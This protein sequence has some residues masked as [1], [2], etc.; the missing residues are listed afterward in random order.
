MKIEKQVD[1]SKYEFE[2]Y[3]SKKRWASMWHQIDE[4][5]KLRPKSVL[6]IGPGPGVFKEVCKLFGVQVETL[7]IDPELKPDHVGSATSLFFPDNAFEVICAFQMLEHLPYGIALESFKEMVRVSKRNIIISLPDSRPI[8]R[9]ELHIPKIG[10]RN[11]HVPRPRLSAPAHQFD[12]EHYWEVNKLGYELDRIVND[13][14]QLATIVRTY[15]VAENPYHRFFIF[16][17]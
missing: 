3:V 11:F 7:D 5:T 2:R 9:Y 4:I 1:K 13:F 14:G 6:E 16:N 12:G 17:T 10:S 15:R 8:W